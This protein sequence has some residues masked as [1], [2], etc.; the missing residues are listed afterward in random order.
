VGAHDEVI[1][2][3][4]IAPNRGKMTGEAFARSAAARSAG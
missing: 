2:D 4:L 3:E 1:V